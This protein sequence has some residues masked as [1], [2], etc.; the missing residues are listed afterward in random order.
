MGNQVKS[1]HP[2]VGHIRNLLAGLEAMSIEEIEKVRVRVSA[3]RIEKGGELAS[4]M[5]AI[6]GGWNGWIANH[7]V[8]RTMCLRSIDRES[9][10]YEATFYY[11][12]GLLAGEDDLK[13]VIAETAL[14]DPNR[15]VEGVAIRY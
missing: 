6:G 7:A 1:E 14:G 15:S 4:Y 12:F 8:N 10:N 3:H 13:V 2:L 9:R 11:E 5:K